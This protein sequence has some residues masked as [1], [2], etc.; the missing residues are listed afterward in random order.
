M[1]SAA[2]LC[3]WTCLLLPIAAG[4]QGIAIEGRVTDARGNPLVGA[5]VRVLGTVLGATADAGGHFSIARIPPGATA[6]RVTML[7]YETADTLIGSV[8]GARISVEIVLRDAVLRENEVV[9]TAGRRA[10][11]FSEIPVSVSALDGGLLEQRN[12]VSLDDALRYVP[13][14][15]MT[16]SQVNIRGSSGYSRGLGARVLLLVD[17]V[18]LLSGDAGDM[19]FDAVPMYTI[20]RVEVVKGAGSALYG[21]S[22]LGGVVNVITKNPD[23]PHLR[24]RVTSGMYDAPAYEQWKWWGSSPRFYNGL[25]IEGG[26][27]FDGF[28]ATATGG[29]R[30]NQG[31]RRN[32]D[33]FRWNTGVK[34]MQRFTSE[35]HLVL[36]AQYYYTDRGNWIFWKDLANALVPPDDADVSERVIST[37]FHAALLY[38]ETL[39]PVF[40]HELRLH[41][42]RTGVDTRSDT[43]DFSTRPLDRTQSDSWTGGLTWQGTLSP[44]QGHT[45]ICGV[46][47]NGSTVA[48]R[49]YGDRSGWTASA[50]A[51]N[52]FTLFE[53]L[54]C[55][56]GLRFDYTKIDSLEGDGLLTPRIGATYTPAEGTVLRASYGRGFRSASIAE[57]FASVSASGILTKPNPGLL[58]ER[59]TSYEIGIRQHLSAPVSLDLALF[60]N[61]YDQLIEPVIDPLDGRIVFRNITR[62]RIPGFEA[63]ISAGLFEGILGLSAGYTYMYPRDL[64]VDPR[65][66]VKGDRPL[67]YRPRH[68]LVMGATFTWSALSFGADFRYISRTEAIDEELAIVIKDA[69]KRVEAFITDARVRYELPD[70]WFPHLS[71]SLAVNNVFQ[72]NYS[73]IVGNLAPIR[74]FT[75]AIEARL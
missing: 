27:V 70:G 54:L 10:Q 34:L 58:S 3:I 51:Q 71:A 66:G 63:G 12:Q 23:R 17:G 37:K 59:S 65:T 39:S 19:K 35:R 64:S 25:D 57:R 53:G 6:L 20:D 32:D 26:Y 75:L 5:N 68:L 28:S 44:A 73:E 47:G 4:A 67:K 16:E 9:I 18:P 46:E 38:R 22:A 40:A 74:S 15:N 21:S 13:G 61:E 31:Y 48:S 55:S 8:A 33:H 7:G 1:T 52:E 29:V 56:A 36:T 49:T 2:R 11:S 69:D 41:A 24:A 72:Y 43:S 60:L 45:I 62:A 50:F 14:V 42:F 30:G